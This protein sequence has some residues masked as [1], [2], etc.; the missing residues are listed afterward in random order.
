MSC[1]RSLSVNYLKVESSIAAAN[2]TLAVGTSALHEITVEN[3]SLRDVY[4]DFTSTCARGGAATYRSHG[5]AW[6]P[7]PALVGAHVNPSLSG[8]T[9]AATLEAPS[10]PVGGVPASE[11]L[12][13]ELRRRRPSA[14]GVERFPPA[15]ITLTIQ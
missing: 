2:C 14:S 7:V 5:A 6:T 15:A 4:V 9:F 1:N 12:T 8:H 10:A 11:Q 13:V 3:L